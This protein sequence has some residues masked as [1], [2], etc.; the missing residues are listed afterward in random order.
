VIFFKYVSPQLHYSL[1]RDVLFESELDSFRGMELSARLNLGIGLPIETLANVTLALKHHRSQLCAWKSKHPESKDELETAEL[2]IFTIEQFLTKLDGDH[3]ELLLEVE[4][5]KNSLVD[6]KSKYSNLEDLLKR[7]T[8][9]REQLQIDF[10]ELKTSAEADKKAAQHESEKQ[11]SIIRAFDLIRMYRYY[12]AE[13]IVGGDWGRFCEKYY[14]FEDDVYRN[15]KPQRDFDAFLAPFDAQ[16]VNGLTISTIM[17]ASD[18]RHAIAHA[19]IRSAANQ[20]AFLD[21]CSTFDFVD[22]Q[23]K[24]IASKIL[25]VLEKISLKRMC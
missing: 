12:F 8:A 7:E 11:K 10:L 17:K 2:N 20:K 4:V 25:P 21:E 5:L 6:L 13:K 22:C 24:L 18:D 23:S 19:N 9:K 14:E 15:I 1:S 3:S 16:L